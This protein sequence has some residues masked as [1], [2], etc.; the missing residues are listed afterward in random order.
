GPGQRVA[1]IQW[2]VTRP[3]G[4]QLHIRLPPGWVK[5]GPIPKPCSPGPG[6]SQLNYRLPPG[7]VRSGSI[8]THGSPGPGDQQEGRSIMLTKRWEIQCDQSGC[9]TT[10]TNLFKS[11]L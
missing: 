7:W 11:D 10:L 5:V 3:G 1:D 6:G 2:K 9:L 8:P 4:A